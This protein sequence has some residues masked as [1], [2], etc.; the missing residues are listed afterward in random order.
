[1]HADQ[2]LAA[3]EACADCGVD[4]VKIGLM[5]D[6]QRAACIQALKSLAQRTPL[7]AVLFRRSGR[8]SSLRVD[9]IAGLVKL[10]PELLGFRGALCSGADRTA[11]L[12]PVRVK[13]VRRIIEL[14][15]NIEARRHGPA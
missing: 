14:C 8:A 6:P 11:Q 13:E 4:V 5:P 9:D 10:K 12:D 3:S 7:V 15:Q 1:M 2:L